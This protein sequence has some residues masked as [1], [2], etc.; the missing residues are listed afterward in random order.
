MIDRYESEVCEAWLDVDYS[1]ASSPAGSS[2]RSLSFWISQIP[3][4]SFSVNLAPV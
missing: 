2:T 3:G 1:F 4:E